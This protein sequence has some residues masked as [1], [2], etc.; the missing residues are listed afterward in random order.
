M[1]RSPSDLSIEE[2]QQK[3]WPLIPASEYKISEFLGRGSYASVAGAVRVKDKLKV[4]IKRIDHVFCNI[5]DAKRILREVA[6][7]CRAKH[8]N[9]VKLEDCIYDETNFRDLYLVLEYVNSDLGKLIN[10][11]NRLF[12]EHIKC[13]WLQLLAALNY[14][15]SAQLIHRDVKPE[16]VLI[17]PQCEVKLCDFG[18]ARSFDQA[19]KSNLLSPSP[20]PLASGGLGSPAST[21]HLALQRQMTQHVVTRWYRAPELIL[22]KKDY[23]T[24]IDMW[25]VACVIAEML[26]LLSADKSIRGKRKVLFPGKSSWGMSPASYE[27]FSSESDFMQNGQMLVIFDKLGTPSPEE[28][29]KVEDRQA[30]Q[31]LERVRPRAGADF[32]VL[33]PD[34]DDGALDLIKKMLCFDD[35]QR[36]GVED[37]IRHVYFEECLKDAEKFG[38]MDRRIELRAPEPISLVFDKERYPTEKYVKEKMVEEMDRFA[39]S[40]TPTPIVTPATNAP[41]KRKGSPC[42]AAEAEQP[43][44]AHKSTNLARVSSSPRVRALLP[45]DKPGPAINPTK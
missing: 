27:S 21:A 16:N 33:Y 45:E 10:A 25:S 11:G 22:R 31:L 41:K 5:S 35:E 8:P 29:A 39:A 3:D 17:S 43:A 42:E 18:L 36:L 1:I 40:P 2:W 44:P 24:A 23:S 13:I 14:L 26:P 15:H 20:A 32:K 12:E 6:I 30:R 19:E 37:A 9:I 38:D 28:V 34:A 7:L 4:A